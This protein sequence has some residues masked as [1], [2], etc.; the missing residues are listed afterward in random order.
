MV[1]S[2]YWTLQIEIKFY[3]LVLTLIAVGQLKRI[4]WWLGTWLALS[5]AG[6]FPSAP[7]WVQYAGLDS[8][9]TYFIAGCY[10]Y[11]VRAGNALQWLLIP[12]GISLLLGVH[13][14]LDVQEGFT[15]NSSLRVQ[16]S[17]GSIVVIEY[18]VFFVVAKRIW[19]LP[20]SR[21]WY[22]LGAMTYPLYL[23]HARA[24]YV[25]WDLL[26]S[27]YSDALRELLLIG[28]ALAAALALAATVERK[29]C[30]AL[31]R[32]LMNT[33]SGAHRRIAQSAAVMTAARSP[34]RPD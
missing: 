27:Y 15:H 2:V 19:Q 14:A 23:I 1:D 8:Y 21:T 22:W 5:I 17:V 6:A 33:I 16:L 4:H 11:L 7:H 34:S 3:A 30:P 26:P 25:V 12:L 29:A 24:G 32:W 28:F 10:L 13:N 20:H 31:N 9:S 18:L